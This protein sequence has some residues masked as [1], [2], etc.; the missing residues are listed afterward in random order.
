MR[1]NGLLT[2]ALLHP[3][4]LFLCRAPQVIDIPR[5][6]VDGSIESYPN[7]PSRIDG[8]VVRRSWSIEQYG[9]HT[10]T[11]RR[12]GNA[13]NGALTCGGSGVQLGMRGGGMFLLHSIWHVR[14]DTL[15]EP[16]PRP[17]FWMARTNTLLG[18]ASTSVSATAQVGG[19]REAVDAA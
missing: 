9:K 11:K 15:C 8:Y 13:R 2:A 18:R 16:S 17:C 6:A 12:C 4:A 5:P 14:L 3:H 7:S 1:K 10:E 19:Q